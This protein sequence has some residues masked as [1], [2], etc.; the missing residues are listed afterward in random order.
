MPSLSNM[1]KKKQGKITAMLAFAA[2]LFSCAQ[3]AAKG[4]SLDTAKALLAAAQETQSQF[5]VESTYYSFSSTIEENAVDGWVN[6]L[7]KTSTLKVTYQAPYLISDE[8]TPFEVTYELTI[9]N[10]LDPE[11]NTHRVISV[12]KEE[13]TYVVVELS[14]R[15]QY[16]PS[17]DSYLTNFMNLPSLI[18]SNNIASLDIASQFMNSIGKPNSLTS[19]EVL[20][21]G[22]D[23]FIVTFT[24]DTLSVNNLYDE[25]P[26]MP[27]DIIIESLS[28]NSSNKRVNSYE[29]QYSHPNKTVKIDGKPF[30][31]FGDI[32]VGFTYEA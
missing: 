20:S 21:E 23:D 10:F 4:V 3:T 31:V 27:G 25:D 5:E 24:G 16:A 1:K 22:K 6:H 14:T 17:T 29:S 2:A 18:N 13:G 11:E 9:S 15:H 12:V 8:K 7:I 30:P 26:N 32:K 19:F 28:V